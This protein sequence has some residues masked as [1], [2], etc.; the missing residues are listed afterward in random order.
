MPGWEDMEPCVWRLPG[1]GQDL[2]EMVVVTGEKAGLS[3]SS[4]QGKPY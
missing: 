2:A 1:L 3:T 4:V